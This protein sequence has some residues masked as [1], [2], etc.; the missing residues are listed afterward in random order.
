MPSPLL[1][2]FTWLT[3]RD[4]LFLIGMLV[5]VC[6]VWGFIHLADSIRENHA[7]KFDEIANRYFHEHPGPPL[8]AEAARDITGM[9]GIVVLT[10]VVAAVA[11]FLLITRRYGMMVFVLVA[12]SGGLGLTLSLKHV[13]DR[14]RPAERAAGVIVYTQSFPSGH[15][16]LSAT[17]YLTLGGLLAR[18]TKSRVLQ[19]YFLILAALASFLIGCSRIYLGAHYPTDV[20]AGWTIGL[21]WSLFCWLVARELQRRK[22]VERE[23]PAEGS[24]V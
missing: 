4:G 13:I 2:P 17:I 15:S 14:P 18:T 10:L 23:A 3:N 6:G 11:G 7:P 21:V 1:R 8:V 20:L 22:V 5:V 9:G 12:T 24:A 16:V 19:F